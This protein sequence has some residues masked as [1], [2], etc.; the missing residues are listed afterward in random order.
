MSVRSRREGFS[1]IE[2][3]IVVAIILTL[4]AIAIPN[5]VRARIQANETATISALRTLTSAVVAYET[6]YQQGYPNSLVALGPP[7]G[8][9]PASISAADLIDQV[10][11]MGFRSGYSFSYAAADTNGDGKNDAYTVN[12]DPSSPGISGNR[13]FF[14]NQ[15]NVI[16]QNATAA[17]GPTDP[18]VS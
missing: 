9:T 5:F 2:L 6:T 4:A 14:V 18:P 12:A 10:L 8:G 1:L 15:G 13:H 16:R 7:P 11:A 3:L 17:A